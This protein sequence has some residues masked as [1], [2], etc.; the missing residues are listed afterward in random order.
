MIDLHPEELIDQERCGTL[1]AADRRR[2][3]AHRA[4]CT[5]CSFEVAVTRNASAAA[6]PRPG[7]AE[8]LARVVASS[9][10]QSRGR[11]SEM[12]ALGSRRRNK[13]AAAILFAAVVA[14][15]ALAVAR[16]HRAPKATEPSAPIVA[17][18]AE[19]SPAPTTSSPPPEASTEA[20]ATS[21]GLPVE[22]P[23]QVSHPHPS[24]SSGVHVPGAA[25]LYTEANRQRRL[26]NDAEAAHLYRDLEKRYPDSPEA[27][28][29]RVSY[30][31]LLLDRLGDPASA[32][33]LFDAYLAGEPHGTLQEEALLG[34]AL[35]LQR[36]GRTDDERAAW[37]TLIA[38][39]PTSVHAERARERLEQ[40][41]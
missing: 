2:L 6:E 3:E 1:S 40:L 21:A 26:G 41:R 15:A 10:E 23:S 4:Q 32:L 16:R 9:L 29:S 8:L 28:A 14:A 18:S 35:S 5:A 36:L 22:A 20:A 7:D 34:R 39:H 27:V 11:R 25:E 37:Q 13:V 31:R 38:E 24:T 33:T 12:R 17:S 19:T 30:G